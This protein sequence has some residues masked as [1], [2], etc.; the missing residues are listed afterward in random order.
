MKRVFILILLV[1]STLV[2][3]AYHDFFTD[4]VLRIDYIR[5]GNAQDASIALHEIYRESPWAGSRVNL[6]DD[7]FY[8]EYRIEVKAMSVNQ[9]IFSTGYSSL[10]REWQTTEE[11]RFRVKAFPES[12]RIPFPRQDVEIIFLQRAKDGNWMEEFRLAVNPKDKYIVDR[13]SGNL[14]YENIIK[15]GTPS[16]CLD[17]VILA[18]GYTAGQVKVFRQDAERFAQYL[19][20]ARP[21]DEYRDKINI[22]AVFAASRNEGPDIPGEGIWN[23][24]VLH[25]RF[26]TFESERYLTTAAYHDVMNMASGAP[27]D[28]VFILVNTDRYGGGGIY[29]FYAVCSAKHPLSDFVFIHEFGHAFAG[30]GD[31]YYTS[32]V[33]YEGF[34]NPELEPW[35]PNLTTLKNFEVKWKDM[36]LESTPIPTPN[37]PQFSAVT[38]VFEGGGY[39]AKGIYRP[40][41][42][43]T[44]KS[45]K[46]DNFCPVCQ[47]AIRRMMQINL[48]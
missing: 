40:A 36:L 41:I 23:N 47:R 42:D 26:Y 45:A 16:H 31:E 39:M 38:G 13:T 11:A 10:F 8:G 24:T 43:C 34:Y 25:S 22:R 20:N 32:D 48:D 27:W 9:L 29:N 5:S 2:N 35:E 7:F 15:S 28:Q 33:A 19:L 4:D 44:M 37:Q 21:F 17:V 6:I 1:Y 3:A 14:P 18:E 46:Y 30:L 12:V